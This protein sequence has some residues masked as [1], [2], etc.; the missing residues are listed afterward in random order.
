MLAGQTRQELFGKIAKF[1]L[2]QLRREGYLP[3]EATLLNFVLLKWGIWPWNC[4]FC[5][6]MCSIETRI[7][8]QAGGGSSTAQYQHSL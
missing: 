6:Y 5:A 7:G 8:T 4:P 1:K 3:T 2:G